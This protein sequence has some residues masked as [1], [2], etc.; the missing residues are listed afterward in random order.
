MTDVLRELPADE[1]PRERLL[2]HG[3][4]TLSD[5]ELVAILLGSGMRGK[6][7][8]QVAR[9]LLRD[10]VNSLS[11]RDAA[12]LAKVA[13]VGPAKATRVVAALEFARRVA[14]DRPSLPP[15]VDIPVLGDQLVRSM[16]RLRQ[17]RLGAVLLD[18]RNRVLKQHND[19]YIGTINNAFVSTRD[20]IGHVMADNALGVVIFHNHPSGDPSPSEEDRT[21]TLKL[22]DS[23]ALIDVR[24]VDHLIIGANNHYA[25]SSSGILKDTKPGTRAL[26]MVE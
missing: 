22:R 24:L 12:T 8:I 21:Y 7:A 17:E 6:N 9:E 5:S 4:E 23:L 13:G 26:R 15:D 2:M 20:L 18:A 19:I 1:R 25:I 3:A 10:G 16:G 11:E 14:S